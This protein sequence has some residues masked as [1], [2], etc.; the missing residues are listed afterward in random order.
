MRLALLL[1]LLLV[2]LLA[3]FV[4][5]N[6]PAFNA[7]APLSLGV[8]NVEAPLGL[9]MLA[10]LI[11]L[12]GPAL[13]YI[14]YLQRSW[15]IKAGRDAEELRRLHELAERAEASRFTELREL[16]TAET[17]KLEEQNFQ[18][19]AEFR[20]ELEKLSQHLSNNRELSDITWPT[21]DQPA[22]D[23]DPAAE[24]A[25]PDAATTPAPE[26]KG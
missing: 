13:L 15:L 1:L 2:I 25:D 20:T 21:A 12:V 19:R 5:L 10:L 8:V 6:W 14:F 16:L 9:I 23:P 24:P 18:L 22:P 4:L 3:G 17:Q 26:N 11:L 7:A